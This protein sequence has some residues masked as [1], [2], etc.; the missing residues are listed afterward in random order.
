MKKT[1]ATENEI[2]QAKKLL[3]DN[4]YIIFKKEKGKI[5]LAIVENTRTQKWDYIYYFGDKEL[6]SSWSCSKEYNFESVVG[7]YRKEVTGI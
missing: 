4:D 3:S 1:Q 7:K 5:C 2:A 6:D